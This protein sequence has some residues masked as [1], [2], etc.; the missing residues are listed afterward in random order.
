MLVPTYESTR[1]HDVEQHRLWCRIWGFHGRQHEVLCFGTYLQIFQPRRISPS[2]IIS[3]SNGI[4]NSV[5]RQR[6]ILQYIWL[7]VSN[8]SESA[9]NYHQDQQVG[10]TPNGDT[11]HLSTLPFSM[12]QTQ[13]QSFT[14]SSDSIPDACGTT[15][16]S[17]VSFRYATSISAHSLLFWLHKSFFTQPSRST[18]QLVCPWGLLLLRWQPKAWP[19]FYRKTTCST[20][21]RNY[22]LALTT[23]F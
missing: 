4:Y 10:P 3:V 19:T 23:L 11:M 6:S 17:S 8:I 22:T 9:I 21:N 1:C 13:Y 5:A 7:T 14:I 12:N 18:G 20:I 2:F 15:W 16:Y